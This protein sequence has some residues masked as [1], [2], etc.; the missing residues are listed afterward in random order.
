MNTLS[1]ELIREILSHLDEPWRVAAVCKRL[2][3]ELHTPTAHKLSLRWVLNTRTYEASPLNNKNLEVGLQLWAHATWYDITSIT[4]R[5]P[6]AV[7]GMGRAF[8][9]ALRSAPNLTSLDLTGTPFRTLPLELGGLTKLKTLGLSNNMLFRTACVTLTLPC[10]LETLRVVGNHIRNFEGL[11]LAQAVAACPGLK[12]LDLSCNPLRGT[13]FMADLFANLPLL[14]QVFLTATGLRPADLRRTLYSLLDCRG[15]QVLGL[16]HLA[17]CDPHSEDAREL[18]SDAML[19]Q[20]TQALRLCFQQLKL[21]PRLTDLSFAGNYIGLE[22]PLF[23]EALRE[24]PAL[25]DLDLGD[26]SLGDA[27]VT[28]IAAVLPVLSSLTSLK[29]PSCDFGDA[30]ARPLILGLAWCPELKELWAGD[31]NES[32]KIWEDL[33]TQ[34]FVQRTSY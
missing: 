20:Q 30:G 5:A 29:V 2:Y 21:F 32:D 13:D 33:G 22:A 4:I 15:L 18:F 7:F 9:R 28:H 27:G 3:A 16:S 8:E 34:V 25:T 14:E 26:T 19:Q 31:N 12:I 17:I 24:M 10:S 1:R 11:Y 23:A 6:G